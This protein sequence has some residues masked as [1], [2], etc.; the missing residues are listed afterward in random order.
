MILKKILKIII[1]MSPLNYI[2]II[3]KIFQ[4]F[5]VLVLLRGGGKLIILII[6]FWFFDLL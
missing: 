2:H 4:L 6:Y 5:I 1:R 3:L